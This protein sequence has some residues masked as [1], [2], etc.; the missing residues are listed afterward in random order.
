MF[1]HMSPL[2]LPLSDMCQS[3]TNTPPPKHHP[4]LIMPALSSQTSKPPDPKAKTNL[5]PLL[6][7]QPQEIDGYG[8]S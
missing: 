4:Q 6:I 1:L 2:V 8:A 5:S 7:T 3:S